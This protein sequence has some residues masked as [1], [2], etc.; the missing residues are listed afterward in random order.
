FDSTLFALG[1]LLPIYTVASI[2]SNAFLGAR[3][4]LIAAIVLTD[5]LTS[6]LRLYRLPNWRWSL[7]G[8]CF[9]LTLAIHPSKAGVYLA[10]GFVGAA[11]LGGRIARDPLLYRRLFQGYRFGVFVS[12]LALLAA[13]AVVV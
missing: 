7:Y 13:V 12:A 1:A 5:I 9:F 11:L 6:R 4:L 8:F 10:I 3:L 2:T